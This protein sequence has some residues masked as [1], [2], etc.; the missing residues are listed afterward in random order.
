VSVCMSVCLHVCMLVCMSV[1]LYVCMR[2]CLSVGLYVCMSVCMS[3]CW[4]VCIVCLYVCMLVCLSVCLYVCIQ[5]GIHAFR[6]ASHPRVPLMLWDV[7]VAVFFS[8]SNCSSV[9]LQLTVPCFSRAIRC[10]RS[11]SCVS[12]FVE[13]NCCLR[14]SQLCSQFA[15]LRVTLRFTRALEAQAR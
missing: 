12:L 10:L 14:S 6:S 15:S 4:Y 7:R 5:T 3:V 1:C 9:S 8:P 13:P 2:A 11:P